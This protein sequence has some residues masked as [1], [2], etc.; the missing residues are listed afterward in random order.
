MTKRKTN[1]LPK[2]T[3]LVSLGDYMMNLIETPE[4]QKWATDMKAFKDESPAEFDRKYNKDLMDLCM[5]INYHE[6]VIARCTDMIQHSDED[7]PNDYLDAVWK[8]RM[9]ETLT[10]ADL[11]NE[12]NLLVAKLDHAVYN[13]KARKDM[14]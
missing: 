6:T 7:M 1:N 13:E 5:R 2:N 12:Y 4:M 10:V 8:R 3:K 14:S 11:Y 9:N